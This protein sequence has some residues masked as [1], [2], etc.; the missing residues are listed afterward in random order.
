MTLL[1]KPQLY[2]LPSL[3]DPYKIIPLSVSPSQDE[4]RQ[5]RFVVRQQAIVSSSQVERLGKV[6]VIAPLTESLDLSCTPRTPIK[7]LGEV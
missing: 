4:V 1:L 5:I 2:I 7:Q 3:S 6:V